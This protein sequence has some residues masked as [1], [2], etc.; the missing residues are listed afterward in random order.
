MRGVVAVVAVV[1]VG[2]VV[3]TVT[4]PLDEQGGRAI[5]AKNNA[6]CLLLLE[7]KK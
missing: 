2:A 6:F 5:P 3:T 7:V 1:A 4:P